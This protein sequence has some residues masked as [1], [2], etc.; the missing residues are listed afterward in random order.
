MQT[1]CL[2]AKNVGDGVKFNKSAA[3]E[4]IKQFG[5]KY[6]DKKTKEL[7]DELL[8]AICTTLPPSFVVKRMKFV[9]DKTKAPLAHQFY[10]GI[11]T[12]KYF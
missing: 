11:L 6:S 7:V 1:A 4:L 10:L 12:Y 9:M 2:A 8:T 3:W 5:D